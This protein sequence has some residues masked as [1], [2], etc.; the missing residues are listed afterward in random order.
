MT[1]LGA[2]LDSKNGVIW[3]AAD[4]KELRSD[5]WS[6]HSFS[7]ADIEKL[8]AHDESLAWG[9]YGENGKG[10]VFEYAFQNANLDTWDGW[11]EVETL[12]VQAMSDLNK[13][14]SLLGTIFGG[15]IK[16]EPRILGITPYGSVDRGTQYLFHGNGSVAA[17]AIWLSVERIRPDMSIRDRLATAMGATIKAD[18]W[19]GLPISLWCISARNP[20]ERESLLA[21]DLPI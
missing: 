3:L 20:I 14:R 10:S 12:C 15:F 17:H 8:Y 9:Y 18:E 16:G 11:D 13:G 21:E 4:A 19:L 6:N 2:A 7:A 5:V 1:L